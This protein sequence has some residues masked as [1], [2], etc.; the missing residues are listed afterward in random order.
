MPVDGTLGD[1][2]AGRDGRR[3]GGAK[4]DGGVEVERGA[5]QTLTGG[6]TVAA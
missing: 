5:E 3:G 2:G 6:L 1:A 4:S